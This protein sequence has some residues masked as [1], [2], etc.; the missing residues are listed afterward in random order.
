MLKSCSAQ[1][2]H[3]V[4]RVRSSHW[5]FHKKSSKYCSWF[6]EILKLNAAMPPEQ[7][8]K[9]MIL[10]K[11][12]N[13]QICKQAS[14]CSN[15]SSGKR[16]TSVTRM[17]VGIASIASGLSLFSICDRCSPRPHISPLC[18]E[19]ATGVLLHLAHT[20]HISHLVLVAFLFRLFFSRFD[21]DQGCCM[22]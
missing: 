13:I 16:V 14:K 5:T 7:K 22:I 12:L 21:G 3:S 10:W 20:M 4:W 6:Y 1:Y 15:I 11:I 9:Y 18:R 2:K 17:W 8:R 19:R